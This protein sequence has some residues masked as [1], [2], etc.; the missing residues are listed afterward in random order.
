M[1]VKEIGDDDARESEAPLRVER[2]GAGYRARGIVHI[3]DVKR[4][5]PHT[6]GRADLYSLRVEL[7]LAGGARV[8]LEDD[9]VGFWTIETPEDITGAD[10]LALEINGERVF[11][12]GVVWMP[13]DPVSLSS[14]REA[15]LERL[16]TFR[17]AGFNLIRIAGTSMYESEDF[18]RACDELGLMVWQ[19]LMFAN[20]D[21]P[22][23]D[24]GFGETARAEV[25]AE[26]SKLARHP[27]FA[28][29]CGNSE[30]EQQ[31]GML[32][33]SSAWPGIFL[34]RAGAANRERMLSWDSLRS[35]GAVR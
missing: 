32:V 26:L 13:I 34:R 21:Y 23:D 18:H 30:I 29:L 28:V 6:H 16:T 25:K 14:S 22:F 31:V 11:C 8:D 19:D 17:D 4:W 3:E 10:G 1:V 7:D 9:P 5:W 27:S 2:S 33:R 15:I 24:A 20:L 12:R 35:F